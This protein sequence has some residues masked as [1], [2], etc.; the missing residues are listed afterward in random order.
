MSRPTSPRANPGGATGLERGLGLREAVALNMI[1]M[2]G[3]GPFVVI[4]LVIKAMGG[5][6]C[7]LAWAAGAVLALLDGF[8]W[9]ELGAAMPLAGGSYV[10]LREAYGPGRM[11]RLMSFLFVWQTLIQA[12]LSLSS[13]AIGFSQYASYLY[14][15]GKYGEKAVSGALVIVLVILLYRKITS[16][17]RISVFLWVGVVGTILWLIWGGAT[18]F[19]P[20]LVFTY[21]PGAWD[22]SWLFFAGLGSATV[23]T[24]YTYWGYYNICH[25][26]GEIRQP[27]RN[28]P[29]GI[30]L[31]IGGIAILYLA[32]QT[33]ILGVLPWQQAQDSPFIVSAFVEKLYGAGAARFATVMVLWI[34]FASVFSS[35]LGYS[36]VPYSAALDGNFFRVFARVHPKK[37]FPH[38]SLVFLG[39]LTFIFSLLFR[40]KTVIAAVLA[41]RLI[42]QFIGQ[43]IGVILLRRRWPAERLPFK[44][45]LY[46]LPALL[47]IAGWVWL[48]LR[49]GMAVCWGLLVIVLGLAVYLVES[50]LRGEWPF[51]APGSEAER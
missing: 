50:R 49:T 27:E 37:H 20:H 15:L 9:S 36:R 32:M 11:G 13:G 12:P 51:G 38:V 23:N 3:I 48:F 47:T 39:G 8:V 30:F 10:F 33:S 41:M 31:S 45:W 26:G 2:V 24:I 14:P 19:Q 1:E 6:Q 35:L 7:L 34:A 17:G 18:H 43:A 40:L 5:P 46:P 21:A 16:I 42:V 44:M 29:R 25:L 28:I 22:F 4:P